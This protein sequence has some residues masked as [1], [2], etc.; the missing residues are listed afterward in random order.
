M[1]II[2]AFISQK[3]GVGKTTLA[4][5]L[6]ALAADNGLSVKIADLDAGQASSALTHFIRM[7]KEEEARE[8]AALKKKEPPPKRAN[9]EV[10]VFSQTRDALRLAPHYDL[11]VL[12]GPAKMTAASL[13]IAKV[14]DLVIQPVSPA[15]VDL[16]PAVAEFKG[17]EQAGICPSKLILALNKVKTPKHEAEARLW[18]DRN[19]PQ[20][21]LWGQALRDKAGYIDAMNLGQAITEVKQ[22]GLRAEAVEAI[23]SL[24]A[25]VFERQA[26]M[27]AA[28]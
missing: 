14:S 9:F 17:M 7:K 11:Y 5:G 23:S 20:Y 13:E 6:A 21:R 12:D 3:G 2:V 16:V 24:M 28:Q 8:S 1:T 19:A 4:L 15:I 18:L 27:E 22:T 10:Q 26:A 25:I